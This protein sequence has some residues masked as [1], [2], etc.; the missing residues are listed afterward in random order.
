MI[1]VYT[2][3]LG[4][5]KTYSMVLDLYKQFRE[6]YTQVYTN[7][8]TLRFPHA[9]YVTP[10][11]PEL[12]GRAHDG[13]FALDEAHLTFDSYFWQRIPE[14][15][16]VAFTMFRKRGVRLLM[17]TQ[18]IDQVATR[19][20]S[21]VG[22]EVKC[23]RIGRMVLQVRLTGS[24]DQG[25]D[26]SRKFRLVPLR[27]TVFGLY[28]TLET[29][30]NPLADL[31]SSEE[32]GQV[33]SSRQARPARRAAPGPRSYRWEGRPGGGSWSLTAEGRSA[34]HWLHS[35]GWLYPRE[36]RDQV[37]REV[38]RRRWLQAFGLR[39]DD[40]PRCNPSSPWLPGWSPSE[41]LEREAAD[42]AATEEAKPGALARAR[43]D[44]NRS[45]RELHM[46]EA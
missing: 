44:F 34:M 35:R 31:P 2:G 19:L 21:L 17:T 3:L 8:A 12:I 1:T 41:V 26:R 39:P 38:E 6:K 33:R 28:D 46:G 16:L 20:R 32:L 43:R 37:Q 23:S 4:G 18:H 42:L 14:S 45:L 22:E 24:I 27:P 7:M 13:L 15:S 9:V 10:S 29:F 30:R 11:D 40:L 36:W 25:R 5:G